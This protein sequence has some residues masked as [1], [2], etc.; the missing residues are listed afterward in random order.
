MQASVIERLIVTDHTSEEY[1][2]DSLGNHFGALGAQEYHLFG[3]PASETLWDG[4]TKS[5]NSVTENISTNISVIKITKSAITVS[6]PKSDRYTI[7]LFKA[8]GQK[9]TTF[10]NRLQAGYHKVPVNKNRLGNNVYLLSV[11]GS[12][13][14]FVRKVLF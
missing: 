2:F 10:T 6:V 1:T 5:N 11:K 4:Q 8:N 14:T 13:S 9:I 12:N 3:C 7:S